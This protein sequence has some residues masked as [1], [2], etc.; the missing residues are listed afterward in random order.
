[1]K[2]RKP[3]TLPVWRSDLY[4]VSG[5]IYKVDNILRIGGAVMVPIQLYKAV[6]DPARQEAGAYL[7][8]NAAGARP[9]TISISELEKIT[10]I[11][12]FPAV[13]DQA[14][15]SAM[16]LLEPKTYKERKKRRY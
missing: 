6:Y 9:V 7:V 15:A 8:D 11:N 5:P 12:M 1:M 3:P 2:F 4:V 16:R 13:S 14:K 10:G